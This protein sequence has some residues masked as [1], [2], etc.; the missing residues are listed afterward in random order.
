[1]DT[2]LSENVFKAVTQVLFL[3]RAEMWVLTPSIEWALGSF[4]HIVAQ[5]HREVVKETGGWAFGIALVGGGNG[6]SRL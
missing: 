1:M 5:T 6:G 3:F 2:K 4:Q